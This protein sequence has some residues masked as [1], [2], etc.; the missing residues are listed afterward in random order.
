MTRLGIRDTLESFCRPARLR[1][2]AAMMPLLFM[3]GT[4]CGRCSATASEAE[5]FASGTRR[6]SSNVCVLNPSSICVPAGVFVAVRIS[7]WTGV[8]RFTEVSDTNAAD[9][10]GCARYEIHVRDRQNRRFRTSEGVVSSFGSVGVHPFVGER[11]TQ[12]IVGSGIELRY[13]HPGC[14]VLLPAPQLE[15]AP[16]SWRSLGEVDLD[17]SRL[18][19]HSLDKSGT[20]RLQFDLSDLASELE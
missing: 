13:A 1:R 18:R 6:P 2:T 7:E 15:V 8:L 11:G 9:L 10:Q 20:R 16:T 3:I 14:V 12:T 5:C 19:W 17:D 4:F